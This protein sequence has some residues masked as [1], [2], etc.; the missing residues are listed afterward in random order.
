[1]KEELG[2]QTE[3][4][5]MRKRM[6]KNL[7]NISV[8][9]IKVLLIIVAGPWL[10]QFF[11]P[12]LVGWLIAQI[13]NPLVRFLEQHLHI[14]RKHSSVGIIVGAILLIVWLC[15]LAVAWTVE[16]VVLLLH[17]VPQ[18][19]QSMSD[20]MNVVFQNLENLAGHLSPEAGEKVVEL[21]GS[22][23]TQ[24]GSIA[25]A[26]GGLTVGMAGNAAGKIPALLVSF[27]FSLLFAYFFTAQ[28]ERVHG[29]FIKLTHEETRQQLQTIGKRMKFAV[30][31]Y[32]K[33]QFK[34][35]F[36][37]FALLTVGLLILRV[38]H[39]VLTAV[40][41]AV[42][43]FLP[44]LGTGTALIPWAILWVLSGNLS[45]AAGLVILYAVTQVTRQLIQ[46][47]MVG[48][49]I[50]IDTLTT[51]LFLFIGYR[52]AGLIGMIVA[53]PVGLILLQLHEAG[54]FAGV[55]AS[56]RELAQDIHRLRT[57]T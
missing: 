13:A 14:V 51:L 8:F 11:L 15:Y 12:L 6:R 26:L 34:I 41:I 39:A 28:S 27:F 22:F 7:L 40:G 53:V 25:G 23:S 37:V 33:A 35:M 30:G 55:T 38:P 21:S 47:K 16:H 48:D 20:E 29:L 19:Y 49:S 43:D 56:V 4:V 3:E 36:V 5:E 31:G 52:V 17:N 54:A 1:M 45:G 24:L 42:L 2:K 18:L 9:L 46:P 57:G 32:F 44:M 10:V 50:G